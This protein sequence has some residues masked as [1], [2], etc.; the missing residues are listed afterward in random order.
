MACLS[1][2]L[3]GSCAGTADDRPLTALRSTKLGALLA[4]LVVESARPHRRAA[5]VELL[6]PGQ[7]PGTGLA[8]LR[9][10]LS[11][12]RRQLGDGGDRQP[13][14][15][16]TAGD[17]QFNQAADYWLDVAEFRTRIGTVGA[18]HPGAEHLC[19][20]CVAALAQAGE[21]Y[22]G[23]F[24]TGVTLPGCLEYDDWVFARQEELHEQAL[25]ALLRLAHCMES[26]GDFCEASQFAHR[27]I[28][29]DP[30]HEPA[31]RL[32][33]RAL[34]KAGRTA[35]ALKDYRRLQAVLARESDLGPSPATTRLYESIV[36]G[37]PLEN[38]EADHGPGLPARPSSG[39]DNP[40]GG[41]QPPAGDR[42]V[43]AEYRLAR[44]AQLSRPRHRVDGRF[45]ALTLLVDQGE[46]VCGDRWTAMD[47]RF[48]DLRALLAA[49]P[50]PA[51]V[52]LGPPGS[53]KSTLLRQT[54]LDTAIANLRGED[55]H[56]TVTFFIQLNQYRVQLGHPLPD[57]GD[58]LAA[59]W[60][61]RYP[62][63]PALG[64]LL[65]TGRML[66]LL[67]AL[68][69]MPAASEREFREQVQNWKDW[70]GG[71][72]GQTPGNRV[73]FSCRT[74][75]YSAPLSTPALPVPQVRIEPLSDDQV[76]DFLRASAPA[77]AEQTWTSIAG[78]PELETL[79][80][81]FYLALLADQVTATGD[82]APERAA[83]FTGF[84]RR[85]L[86]REVERG[87]PV[88]ARE[89]LLSSRDSRR[90]ALGQW[91]HAHQLPERGALLPSLAA[92]AHSMQAAAADG[93][94]SQVR[95]SYDA[96]LAFLPPERNED[97]LQAGLAIGV[98]DEDTRAGEV[99]YRHQLIQEYFAARALA[100]RPNPGL[101]AV[102][103]RA[104]KVVPA[105]SEVIDSLAPTEPLPALPQTGW[106]E[107]TLLAATMATNV[108]EF[109]RGLTAT[110]LSLAGRVAA[111]SEV[112]RR[113]P[114]AVVDE[115]RRA[116]V[117]R[118]RDPG[119]DLRDRI[120][121]AHAVGR[122]EDPRFEQRT[123]PDGA[124][125]MPPLV[126][127]RG[128]VYPIGDDRAIEWPEGKLDAG[129]SVTH[130][131]RHH[132]AI[133]PFHIGMFPVTNAEWA[134]F[135]AAGGYGDERWWETADAVRW[136]RGELV[137]EA[138]KYNNRWWRR[139]FRADSTLLESMVA[140][141]SFANDVVITRWRSWMSLDDQAF[142][143][144]LDAHW[145]PRRRAEPTFWRNERFNR[146]NQ[147]VVGI[148]WY[149]ARAYCRWLSAQTG[150]AIRLPT[151][152]EREA[153]TRGLE[154]RVYAWGDVFDRLKANTRE[155]HVRNL[156]PVGVFPEGDTPDG[157]AD[158]V[159]NVFDWTAS[160]WGEH[161]GD[162]AVVAFRYPYDPTD[163]REDPAA[164]PSMARVARG[165][166]W[167]RPSE[168]AWAAYRGNNLPDETSH[169]NGFR[170][171]VSPD[172]APMPS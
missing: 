138:R 113:L 18:H 13:Y 121:C 135:M 160:L 115:V 43:L 154:A 72:V 58:W 167:F 64:D 68:N 56:D 24:L 92:L 38:G 143:R 128:A 50:N 44:V 75:D 96:A 145:Q 169:A 134:C 95:V 66:L 62:S 164:P 82:W 67:D 14:L 155:T 7:A 83:L 146:P 148:C 159:G 157:A 42:A 136:R 132:V 61:A 51:L 31:H 142:E 150:L 11:R 37:T 16:L 172:G 22:R 55:P 111:Q 33:M 97:I 110:N 116:L 3:L 161:A 5:L 123:G 78:T 10:A 103:W 109:L 17:V 120:A 45:V 48:H 40:A 65:A 141:G 19:D 2:R 102:E 27:A 46:D 77:L 47:A 12:L 57:P 119:A 156:T 163:G 133:Q 53:G 124:Y 52:V 26:R 94:L 85:A 153:A 32:R 130:V 8:D 21:L 147:P 79:R 114:E 112:R 41:A 100:A 25:S 23:P 108:V 15:L 39:R 122:L 101:V 126:G 35:E 54:E 49:V 125:L 76:H 91:R 158:L 93:E 86:K 88:F 9:Q 36:A 152:V 87:N 162:E 165:G 149:E 151:E 106:E 137:N 30:C 6:W 69:E 81:P 90:I 131:P 34:A 99:M 168:N 71:V 60:S 140:D 129:S 139:R 144:A 127:I 4:Y 117:A 105:V 107:T 118:S 28:E 63:L 59:R 1:I 104:A 166:S 98:L 29:L 73:V 89:A 84:V 171:A 74:L 170:L 80:T 20:R 70:L